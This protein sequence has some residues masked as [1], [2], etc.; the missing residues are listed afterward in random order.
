MVSVLT[1]CVLCGNDLC[2]ACCCCGCDVFC[3][4]CIDAVRYWSD[5]FC[6]DS[7]RLELCCAYVCCDDPCFYVVSRRFVV[8]CVS[9]LYYVVNVA[10]LSWC[11]SL[12][13]SVCW[14]ELHCCVAL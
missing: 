5:A 3:A 14:C 6:L 7:R 2:V 9:V 13:L 12:M 10:V 11:V 1:R 4:S 8:L